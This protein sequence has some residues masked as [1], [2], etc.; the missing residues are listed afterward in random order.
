M[1]TELRKDN[2]LALRTLATSNSL[3]SSPKSDFCRAVNSPVTNLTLNLSELSTGR[4]TP[5]RKLS[6]SSLDTPQSGQKPTPE[7]STSTDSGCMVD[8]PSPVDSPTLDLLE[9]SFQKISA[10]KPEIPPEAFTKKKTIAFRRFNSMPVPM[11]RL[12][13]V[14]LDLEREKEVLTAHSTAQSTPHTHSEK[15]HDAMDI[16]A[17]T[18]DDISSDTHSS[19]ISPDSNHSEGS[20]SPRKATFFFDE[21]SSQDSGVGFDR[22]SRDAKDLE[23]GFE[24]AAPKGVP[25]MSR[26]LPSKIISEDTCSPFKYSPVKDVV[27]PSKRRNSCPFGSLDFS[28]EFVKPEPEEGSESPLKFS[29]LTSLDE[30]I[31]DGFLDVLDSDAA[32]LTLVTNSMSSLFNAPVL[33][34]SVSQ[35]DDDTPVTRRVMCRRFMHRSQSVDIRPRGLSFKRSQPEDSSATQFSFKRDPPQDEST[36]IQKHKRRRPISLTESPSSK[37]EPVPPPRL[38]RCHS[39]TEAMIKS[40]LNRIADEPDLVGDCSRPYTLPTFNGKHQD[41]KSIS[42]E[43]LSKVI[44]GEYSHEIEK[45]II[46]DCR[47]PYEFEGGHI[48]GAKNIYTNEAVLEEFLKNP[49][50]PEDPNKRVVLIFHC[51]FSSERGPKLSRFLRSKDR[52]ANKDCYPHLHYPELYLLD[53]GYKSFF[54]TVKTHCVPQTYKPMLHKDHSEDLRHFRTKSKS[55]AGEKNTRPGFRPLKF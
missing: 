16:S 37:T 18:L 11:M 47:Y 9:M 19:D 24:F 2:P 49:I 55:W 53:G 35:D 34:D 36:P 8:S 50:K 5:R 22:D 3:I 28:G 1:T 20:G 30:G 26:R 45:A 32:K 27:S 17:E 43:T 33:T 23:C 14:E 39:E 44:D 4:E 40:A 12:S 54:E 51:E 29:R 52:T 42:S 21:N 31:D 10:L 48:E 6:L 15:A 25:L 41:L 46:V 38:H 13:P 7:R